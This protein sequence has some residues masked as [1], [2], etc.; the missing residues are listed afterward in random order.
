[1]ISMLVTSLAVP[2]GAVFAQTPLMLDETLSSATN[3]ADLDIENEL[4]SATPLP[5]ENMGAE[6]SDSPSDIA[7]G[8]VESGTV[9]S[10]IQVTGGTGK[11]DE[12]VVELYNNTELP[13]DITDWCVESYKSSNLAT[14]LRVGCITSQM[15]LGW[16]VILPAHS[17][18]LFASDAF[19]SAHKTPQGGDFIADQRFVMKAI[20]NNNDGRVVLRDNLGA[21][22]DAVTWGG[23]TTLPVDQG[24][25]R[26]SING[27]NSIYRKFNT[28]TGQYQDSDNNLEDFMATSVRVDYIIGSVEDV[29][30]SCLNIEGIQQDIPDGRYRDDTTGNCADSPP[31]INR[32]EGVM[33]SEISVN[34][35][36]QFIELY[37]TSDTPVALDGCRIQIEGKT[38]EYVFSINDVVDAHN[39]YVILVNDTELSL[40]KT[41]G[42][43]IYLL[44]PD[45]LTELDT[46]S[47][48]SLA[49]DTSWA[50]GDDGVWH[51]TYSITAGSQNEY[52]RYLPCDEG[53]WRNLDTGRCNKIAE[54]SIVADCGQGRERNLETNRCRNIEA[55]SILQPC[56]EDQYRSEE[57]NRCRSIATMA[58]SALKPCADDQFRNPLTNRCKK[59][60]SVD[61]LAD[62]GE[63]PERN[64]ETNRCRNVVS[65]ASMP[66]VAFAVEPIKQTGV[67]FVGWWALGGV[68]LLA[69]GYAGWE[70]RH[71]IYNGIKSLSPK[72]GGK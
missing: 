30:D 41:V 10:Y 5:I 58:A 55:I 18:Y 50:R 35:S 59:I 12:E 43:V 63:G 51:Q 16:R 27:S 34:S 48:K 65:T 67:A 52:Q 17:T 19:A 24:D 57:T 1:M 64:P 9:I 38:G 39:Y 40:P 4:E 47:Y 22:R 53:Y 7:T 66:K 11:T 15:G 45:S 62:C 36:E 68:L 14:S 23:S 42:S 13:I 46:T 70:W 54:Q 3:Q 21:V 32:C 2:Q 60:A 6:F 33:M 56:R 61:E 20:F 69:F 28:N 49:K 29:Y 44:P 8:L 72:A 25:T 26:A 71:E 37:N 31:T